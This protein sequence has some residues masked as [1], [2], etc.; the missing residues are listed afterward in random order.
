MRRFEA[1]WRREGCVLWITAPAAASAVTASIDG[2]PFQ[3]ARRADPVR[4]WTDPATRVAAFERSVAS[5]YYGAEAFPAFDPQLGPGNLATF[6]GSEPRYDAETV[7]YD[8]CIEDPERHPPLAFDPANRHFRTQMALVDAGLAAARGRSPV[9]FPDL[10]ENIDILASLRGTERLLADM[11]DRP[12]WVERQ[13][14]VIN[15][16]WFQVF[17]AIRSKIADAWGGNHWGAFCLW[18]IGRVAKLQCDASAAFG[19][20]QL[21][22]FVVPALREQCRGLDHTLYHLDGTQCI[23]HLE[24]LLAI[25]ELDAVEWTPQAG[26]PG[27]GN[28]RWYD[29]Y[30]R[31]LAAGKC[32]QAV[33]VAAAEVVP[34]L[35]AVGPRGMHII[36]SAS[37]EEEARSVVERVESYRPEWVG[38]GADEG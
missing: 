38:T 35:D 22:R 30:R 3:L 23:C 4:G 10:I 27:G 6:I 32:A 28:P 7:W 25:D 12:A 19:P 9:T 36:A 34:L 37:T 8:P 1:W 26:L 31:I 11:M 13:V 29:L 24:S 14:E 15:G 16:I 18:G 2:D 5:T 33:G 21:K 17:D 20:P